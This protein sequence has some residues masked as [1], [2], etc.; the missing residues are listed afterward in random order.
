MNV[1]DEWLLNVEIKRY[2]YYL[3]NNICKHIQWAG[4]QQLYSNG[5][6]FSLSLQLLAALVT[7][8]KMKLFIKD[9]FT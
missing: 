1:I 4:L 8:Q 5:Q 9:F 2:F 3:S 7:S 6:E